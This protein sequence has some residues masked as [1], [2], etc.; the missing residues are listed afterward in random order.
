MSNNSFGDARVDHSGFDR[1]E[2]LIDGCPTVVYSAGDGP[3]LVFLHGGGTWHGIDFA[4]AWTDRFRVI[5]PYHPGFGQSADNPNIDSLQD[6]L[7]HY[8]ELFEVMGLAHFNL[9]GF[10]LGGRMAAEF[11]IQHGQQIDKLVLIAPAGLDVKEHPQPDFMVIA[12][13]EIPYYL[14]HDIVTLLPFLPNGPDEEF[15]AMRMREGMSVA[16]ISNNGVM[17]NPKLPNWLHRIRMPTLLL[18]GSEDRIVPPGQAEH[19]QRLLPHA[20]LKMFPAAGH[21]VLDEAP[22]ARDAVAGFLL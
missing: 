20:Q 14:V 15:G 5:L 11:A 13:E 2:Y 7:Q 18:W 3:P 10:S 19:W 8:Q 4:R 1:H 9:V 17:T 6:Y 22:Q 16:R 12:P 21:L